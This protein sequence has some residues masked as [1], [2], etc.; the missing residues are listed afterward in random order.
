[1]IELYPIDALTVED[2][3]TIVKYIESY[4]NCSP[5]DLDTILSSWNKNKIKLFKLF[6]RKL[7]IEHHV[8]ISNDDN[9]MVGLLAGVFSP[10]SLEMRDV[11][12]NPNKNKYIADLCR[13]LYM[14]RDEY[15]WEL[16]HEISRLFRYRNFI[17]GYT[18]DDILI[19]N[20]KTNK[21]LKIPC[22]TKIMRAIQ[23]FNKFVGYEDFQLYED[24][25]NEISDIT[26]QSHISATM[27]L[28]I[29]PIDYMTMSHNECD[30]SS[31]M[32]WETGEYCGGTLEMLN[33]NL[34]I[35]CYLKSSRDVFYLNPKEKKY[36]IPNKTWRCLYYA[37]RDLLLAGKPYPYENKALRQK[38]LDILMDLA[39]TN[40]KWN[41]K[42]KKQKFND[43]NHIHENCEARGS[44][45]RTYHSGAITIYT[46][47]MY[48]DMI[49]DQETDY[50]CCRNP[51]N[52]NGKTLYLS[53]SGDA[54]CLRCGKKLDSRNLHHEL[55]EDCDFNAH[56]ATFICRECEELH[57]CE[58][59]RDANDSHEKFVIRVIG[60]YFSYNENERY[61]TM[62]ENCIKKYMIFLPEKE[63]F[64]HKH[65]F[66]KFASKQKLQ[67]KQPTRSDIEQNCITI[68]NKQRQFLEQA[69]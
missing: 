58:I 66:H 39:Y 6:G 10:V 30:W 37:H 3:E 31:C 49:A 5:K 21:L 69:S 27:V 22:R 57:A 43:M 1:M 28:S 46:Y 33:S 13:Y 64:I 55:V 23:R 44:G 15:D 52:K 42:Y 62:C 29:H 26:T 16:K 36:P 35:V 25:R 67:G 41:Y 50:W 11:Y 2:R 9:A 8:D 7:R 18:S 40:M 65:T 38:G 68:Q 48:N 56:G 20:N 19:K 34:A 54:T 59:C 24:F 14:K 53:L 4:A 47:G 45:N 51:R 32:N 61:E 17:N 12:G 63:V 60:G